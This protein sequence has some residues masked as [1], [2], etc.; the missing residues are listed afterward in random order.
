MTPAE[1]ALAPRPGTETPERAWLRLALV[2]VAIVAEWLTD[3]PGTHQAVFDGVAVVALVYSVAALAAA[4]QGRRL[5]SDRV[6]VGV[7]LV[8]L[9]VAVYASGG[10]GSELWVGLLLVPLGA[11]H[12]LPPA[13]TAGWA[14][15][16]VVAYLAAAALEPGLGA[17]EDAQLA[18]GRALLLT[19]GGAVAVVVSIALDRRGE[20]VGELAASRGRLVAQALDADAGHRRRLSEVLHDEALQNLLAVRQELEELRDADP[21]TVRR[22]Q[23][24]LDPAVEVLREAIFDLHPPVLEHV[25]LAAAL[26]GLAAQQARLGG[27]KVEVS[28][29]PEAPGVDDQLVLA[30]ARELLGNVVRHAG[31]RRVSARVAVVDQALLLE[32]VDDGRG[33]DGERRAAAIRE[34]RIG[35]AA[36]GERVEALG[37]RLEIAST[38]GEGTRARVSI[39]LRRER[40]RVPRPERASA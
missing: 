25:G 11:A 29:A 7:D 20:E 27:F 2:A 10:A 31:A 1:L 23:A 5:A 35:L 15:A 18:L 6:L 21:A 30:L 13:A 19:F 14:A 33:F 8:L 16:G 22:A 38:P 37:G 28:V 17:S 12:R 32:V 9:A 34:G 3:R 4:R 39:P 24:A 36:S 26:E 40:R